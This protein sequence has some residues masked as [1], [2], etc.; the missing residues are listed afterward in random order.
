[1]VQFAPVIAAFLTLANAA[2]NLNRFPVT[3]PGAGSS[4]LQR[5]GGRGPR[6]N[7]ALPDYLKSR[8]VANMGRQGFL[9]PSLSALYGNAYG[10][11][12]SLTSVF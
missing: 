9:I 4:R 6:S 1:M 8:P 12:V 5:A 10:N 2:P 3:M 11:K 7:P